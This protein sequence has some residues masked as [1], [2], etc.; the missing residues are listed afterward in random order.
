MGTLWDANCGADEGTF[1]VS[2]KCAVGAFGP[3]SGLGGSGPSLLESVLVDALLWATSV[4]DLRFDGSDNEVS[5]LVSVCEFDDE[6]AV[7]LFAPNCASDEGVGEA[8]ASFV[9]CFC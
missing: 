3:F 6:G 7:C 5:L 1:S 2:V 4:S 8:T 9:P